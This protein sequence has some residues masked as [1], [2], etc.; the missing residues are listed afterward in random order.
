VGN[1]AEIDVRSLVRNPLLWQHIHASVTHARRSGALEL[2]EPESVF[3]QSLVGQ[4]ADADQRA[5]TSLDF[6]PSA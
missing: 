3:W 1:R 2:S 4:V 6:T 5:L